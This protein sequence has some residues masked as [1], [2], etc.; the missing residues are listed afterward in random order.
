MHKKIVILL[1]TVIICL[2]NP[3]GVRGLENGWIAEGNETY[4]YIDGEMYKGILELED[5]D[6]LLG[7]MSGKLYRNGLATTP[8]GRTY[9]TDSAG[10]IKYDFQDYK[11][12]TYYFNKDGMYK[13]ILETENGDYLFGYM[14]GKLYRNGLAT[15]PDNR[16]YLTDSDGKIKYDFQDYK[17]ETYYFD[18]NGMYKGI[19]ETENG[20]YMLGFVSGKLFRNGWAKIPDGN[21]YYTNAEGIIQNEHLILGDIDYDFTEDGKLITGWQHY[22]DKYYYLEFGDYN[23][24]KGFK[25]IDD[26]VYFFDRETA[27]RITGEQ[28]IDN[29]NF[30]FDDEGKM[31]SAKYNLSVY[32]SQ[33]DGRWSEKVYGLSNISKTGCAPTSMAMAFTSILGK[34]ILPPEIADYLYRNTNE[35]NKKTKGSSGL[36]IIYGTDHY[37]I[38]RTALKSKSELRKALENGKIVFAAM[39]DGY[40]G[41]KQWNHAIVM[42]GLNGNS[43]YVQDPLTSSKNKWYSIDDIW[44]QQSKDPD[45]YSGGSN[46]Y[47]LE[48]NY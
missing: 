13:G 11:G 10:R 2:L 17:G 14:S 20:S 35:Y 47:A 43:T 32:Y 42:A 15:T 19:L 33:K 37:N 34:E 44:S 45:D 25:K 39:G 9:L 48:R 6:Y 29:N 1:T 46:F 23:R 12:E 40:F 24:V 8:D 16:T 38:K 28:E 30:V 27:E 5:G 36:A 3:F 26:E 4:Y 18:K 7:Y 21:L 31:L 41:T 22:N